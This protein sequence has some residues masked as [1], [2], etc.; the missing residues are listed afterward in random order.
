[1][2]KIPAGLRAEMER[3]P[4]YKRCAVSGKPGTMVKIDWHHNLIFAGK[5]VNEKWCIIPLAK[6]I[7]DAIVQYKDQVDWIMLNRASE[8]DLRR[9]SKVTDLIRKRDQLNKRFGPWPKK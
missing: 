1:M 8:E 9:Y 3:D 6:E 5:Q 4:F 7:H 2:R